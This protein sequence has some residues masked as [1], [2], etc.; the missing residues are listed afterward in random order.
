M[1]TAPRLIALLP[2]LGLCACASSGTPLIFG[3]ATT[4]GMSVNATPDTQGFDFTL[5]YKDKN[6]AI[7]PV[8]VTTDGSVQEITAWSKT[9]SDKRDALS[10]FGQFTSKGDWALLGGSSTDATAAKSQKGHVKLDRFFATG[11]AASHLANG[12]R[13]GLAN[14][15][16]ADNDEC[17]KKETANSAPAPA[18]KPKNTSTTEHTANKQTNA[19]NEGQK[20]QPPS[21]LG[22]PPEQHHV[23]RLVYGQSMTVGIGISVQ[24][25]TS[26]QG[27]NFTIGY[28]G[29]DIAII[30]TMDWNAS[31]GSARLTARDQTGVDGQSTTSNGVDGKPMENPEDSREVDAYSVFGQFSASTQAQSI[32]YGLSRFFSTGLAA[33]NLAD[34]FEALIERQ[35]K[36]DSATAKA[37]DDKKPADTQK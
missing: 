17:D 15:V 5:G 7:V 8:A 36:T 37:K 23:R 19:T 30:P 3:S 18:A 25:T 2:V 33:R 34:G 10:V 26:E 16:P 4:F 6:L 14:T 20:P 21:A 29:R 1:N 27:P 32:D 35:L 28:S 13:R 22:K 11:I 24:T 9:C 31:G 12:Y